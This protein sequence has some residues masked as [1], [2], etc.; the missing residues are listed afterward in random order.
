[1]TPCSAAADGSRSSRAS[2]RSAAV[3][4][5]GQLDRLQPLA[6]L[7]HLGAFRVAFA[8]LVLDRLQ[9]LAEEELALALLDLRLHL[10]LDLR[11]ELEHLELA[12]EDPRD[13]A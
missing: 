1:M 7:L 10:R 5:L 2:S 13:V 6:E 8:E 3:H 4:V 12:V 9:L 11:A